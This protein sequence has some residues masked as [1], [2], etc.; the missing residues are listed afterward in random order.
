MGLKDT[1]V[2]VDLTPNRPDCASVIGI[3]REVAG[4][5]C[6]SPCSLPVQDAAIAITSSRIFRRVEDAEL[7][8]RY[9]GAPDQKRQ[10][11]PSPWWLRKRLLS[12]GLRPINNIVDITNFVMMEYGQPLHAFDFDTLAGKKIVVRLPRPTETSFTTLDQLNGD[13]STPT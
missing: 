3:A 6:G 9:A 5:N 7:C 12:V 1:M 13:S 4:I 8:P 11:R 2:E 10:D